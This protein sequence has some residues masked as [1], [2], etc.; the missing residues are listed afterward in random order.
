MRNSTIA[1]ILAVACLLMSAFFIWNILFQYKEF[2]TITLALYL[3]V[4]LLINY[5]FLIK[6]A[7][8]LQNKE[9]K[10]LIN[11]KLKVKEY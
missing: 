1:V 10:A 7:E 3:V 4:I 9:D 5:V 6:K 8:R 11:R 2:E